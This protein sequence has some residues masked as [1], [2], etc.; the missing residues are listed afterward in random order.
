MTESPADI[1]ALLNYS[2]WFWCYIEHRLNIHRACCGTGF[3][4]D[5]GLGP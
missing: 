5:R 1:K 3:E 4:T 2:L